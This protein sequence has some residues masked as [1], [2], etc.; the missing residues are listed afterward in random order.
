[1]AFLNHQDL[2][3]I[4]E[5]LNMRLPTSGKELLELT[6]LDVNKLLSID[7][8]ALK[9]FKKS[10]EGKFSKIFENNGWELLCVHAN[11]TLS[12]LTNYY[13]FRCHCGRVGY[14]S[15]TNASNSTKCSSFCGTP[16]TR[17]IKNFMS[18]NGLIPRFKYFAGV[19]KSLPF[20]CRCGEVYQKHW[21]NLESNPGCLKCNGNKKKLTLN[22]V[23]DIFA[24]KSYTLLTEKYVGVMATLRYKC[25]K[26]HIE[27][28]TLNRFQNDHGCPE[29]DR[30]SRMN[31]SVSNILKEKNYRLIREFKV[32]TVNQN[33]IRK[34]EFECDKGHIGTVNQTTLT[35]SQTDWMGCKICKSISERNE[36]NDI[37]DFFKECGCTLLSKEYKNNKDPLDFVCSCGNTSTIIYSALSRGRRC[38]ACSRQ[39]A[40][41]TYMKAHGYTNPM[42]NLEVFVKN[43]KACYKSKKFIFPSGRIDFVQ[44][45]EPIVLKYLLD[46]NIDE[47]DII[48][49]ST[50]NGI[51]PI[52]RYLDPLT[53]TQRRYYPD[54]WLPKQNKFIEVKSDWTFNREL[55]VN[56]T[57]FMTVANQGYKIE[58]RIYQNEKNLSM[59]KIYNKVNDKIK[60]CDYDHNNNLMDTILYD[61]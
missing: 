10:F 46:N 39:R 17:Y 26:G 7:N 8:I 6:L 41:E 34:I 55:D 9:A 36:Y 43:M 53:D 11:E 21:K 28:T 31:I 15:P 16:T 37:F 2:E 18:D 40:A 42:H 50:I 48:T 14:K 45:Y 54:I 1:M 52:I 56:I 29:C 20:V 60:V 32:K 27:E 30:I 4:A 35:S 59:I 49:P 38:G 23:K 33:I 22:Q 47:K 19:K 5:A 61:C 51:M 13:L 3:D 58:V 44:G 24:Q 25:P 57:K 12:R